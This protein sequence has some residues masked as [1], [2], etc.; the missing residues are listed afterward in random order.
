MNDAQTSS[1]IIDNGSESLKLGHAGDQAPREVVQTVFGQSRFPELDVAL[2]RLDYFVGDE[3]VKKRGLLDLHFPIKN[4]R[5]VDF[6]KMEKVWHHSIFEVLKVDPAQHSFLLT[7]S[8]EYTDSDRESIAEIFF[9]FFGIPSMYVANQ[10]CLGLYSTGQTRG[11]V[12]DSGE[13]GT[14][15]IPVYEGYVSP[16]SLGHS[17]V[18]GK[19]I[20]EYLQRLL[21][22]K[23]LTFSTVHDS[24][25]VK[26]IKESKC[27]VSLDFEK[28][29]QEFQEKANTRDILYE[30]PDGQKI[31]LNC[32]QIEATEALFSP[33][34]IN[35]N[36][37]G[38]GELIYKSYFAIDT[39]VHN[40]LFE[41]IVLCGGNMLFPNISERIC[42]N[43][44][45]LEGTSINFKVY[46]Q[47]ERKYSTWIG[48]SILA[49]LSPFETIWIS[50]K[51]Y[52]ETGPAI[53]NRKRF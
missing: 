19:A 12:L 30:L 15:V 45:A 18:S 46:E 51:E 24:R 21:V 27:Y 39:E 53:V 40:A 8:P 22:G 33:R 32:E 31:N 23:G 49:C 10:G 17:A 13:G 6:E 25:V 16:Y 47:A 29:L 3:A 2:E 50:Q 1:V 28:E 48:G 7:E 43:I 35:S 52:E 36:S 4:R 41:R 44:K 20:T 5:I 42:K 34:L 37:L 14:H 26:D 11:V 9:E 38:L